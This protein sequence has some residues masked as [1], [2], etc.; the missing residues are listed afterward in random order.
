[1]KQTSYLYLSISSNTWSRMSISGG[2]FSHRVA[3]AAR[4]RV[5]L[6]MRY[7]RY[8]IGNSPQLIR[9]S[10][11]K[12]TYKDGDGSLD[13]S[14]GYSVSWNRL[15]FFKLLLPLK[16]SLLCHKPTTIYAT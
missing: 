12:N 16:V 13:G 4:Q 10:P 5:S 8:P 15:A 6:L 9:R 1:M 2:H 7:Y 3:A 14:P 11:W